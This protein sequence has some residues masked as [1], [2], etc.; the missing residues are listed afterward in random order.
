MVA[1]VVVLQVIQVQ[2]LVVLETLE[3]WVVVAPVDLEAAALI[4][5]LL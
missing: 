2:I 3:A 5:Q 1:E 4:Y